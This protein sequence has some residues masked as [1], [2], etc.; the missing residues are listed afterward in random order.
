MAGQTFTTFINAKRTGSVDAEFAQLEQRAAR[1]LSGIQAKAEA[2]TKALGGLTG[3]RGGGGVNRSPIGQAY[4]NG[5]DQAKIRADKLREAQERLARENSSL[6]RGLRTTGQTLQIVQGPLGPIAGRVNAAADALARLTGVTLGLAGA[7]AALFAYTQAA[8][9]FVEIRSKLMPLFEAQ[10]DVNQALSD[11][12]GIAQR[13]RAGLEPVIDLYAKMKVGADQLGMSQQRV[14]RI[15][16][17]ASKAATLSGG[18]AQS[19]EAGLYQFSQGFGSGTLAGEE[20][21]SVKENT[22]ALARAISEGL[23]KLPEFKGIDTSIGKLKE[24]GEQG[25]LTAEVIARALEASAGSIEQR[26]SRLPP[27]LGA[28]MTALSNS[29]T[30][31]VGRFEEA[32]GIVGTL[33]SGVLLLGNNLNV[34][35]GVLGGVAAAWA[36]VAIQARAAQAF[37]SAR[38]FIANAQATRQSLLQA[39]EAAVNMRTAIVQRTVALE[40]E[41]RQI[42]QN[43]VALE[44]ELQVQREIARQGA[45]SAKAGL[46]GGAQQA[47]LGQAGAA[48]VTKELADEVEHLSLVQ[49]QAATTGRQLADANKKVDAAARGA[50]K[51]KSLLRMGLSNVLAMMN[52]LG[53]AV[54]LATTAFLNWALAESEAEKNARKVED[55]QRKLATVIDFTTGK[56]I[57]QNEAL[58]AGARL[59]AAGGAQ[60]AF[61]NYS[62]KKGE[63]LALGNQFKPQIRTGRQGMEVA[64]QVQTTAAQRAFLAALD[65][66]RAGNIDS[67]G[68]TKFTEALA[69]QDPAMRA[70]ADRVASLGGE[71]VEAAKEVES[72]KSSLRILQGTATDEDRR[73]A[74]KDFSG[75]RA[76]G[77]TAS[78][79]LIAEAEALR[80]RLRDQRFAAETQM[81][82]SLARLE[83]RRS[84]MT[85]DDYVRERAQILATYDTALQSI[86]KQDQ[87]A[88]RRAEREEERR[89]KAHE[90]ELARIEKENEARDRRTERRQDILGRWS[91]EPRAVERAKIDI[92]ELNDLVGK[93][94]NGLQAITQDN[95]LGQG[96]YTQEM[97]D[98]DA[99]RIREGL[100]RPYTEFMQQRQRDMNISQLILEGHEQEAEALRQT[101]DLYD[102]IGEVTMDQYQS[103]L[104]SLRAEE[105][106]NDALAQRERLMAPLRES[107][108]ALRSE[109]TGAIEDF[110]GGGN[111]LK[112]FKNV[113]TG[114][115]KSFNHQTAVQWAEKVTG[116][117]DQRVRDLIRGSVQVDTKI[118]DYLSALNASGDGATNLSGALNNAA[119]AAN[120][121]A[122]ALNGVGGAVDPLAPLPVGGA[123]GMG[124]SSIIGAASAALYGMMGANI[125]GS[126]YKSGVSLGGG[127]GDDVLWK[128]L[129]GLGGV[130]TENM[131]SQSTQDRYYAAGLTP[132]R[133]SDHTTTN[134]AYDVRPPAGMS[135]Q[136]A[137]N[138]VRKTA[139]EMGYQ[140]VKAIDETQSGGTGRHA[141]YVFGRGPATA[142]P[143]GGVLNT[144][145]EVAGSFIG[146]MPG[147]VAVQAIK[148]VAEIAQQINP[149]TAGRSA[150][151]SASVGPNGEIIITGTRQAS[152]PQPQGGVLSQ[153][154]Q[155]N[156]LGQQ[157]GQ[158]LDKI[159]G[160]KFLGKVGS[161]LG[162]TLQGIQYGQ[163]AS[164]VGSMLGI[165]QSNTGAMI[166]GAIG[167]LGY[168]IP[169]VG[170]IAGPILS[171]V[172]GFLGGT[173]GGMFKKTKKASVTVSG[174]EGAI[175]IG[176]AKGNSGKREEAA[177]Q[178]GSSLGDALQ[179]IVDQLDA[180]IGSFAVSI[181]MRK[182]KYVVDPSG[183]GQTKGSGVL[184]FD[185]A[186]EAIQAALMDAIRDGAIAGISAA[187]QTILKKAK[188][189]TTALNKVMVIE[190]IPKRLMQLK[191]PV[192]Y[193]IMELNDEFAKMI[194]YLKEGGATAQQFAE[195]QELYDLERQRIL[196]QTVN[197]SITAIQDYIDEMLGGSSSP[198]NR[199]TVYENAKSALNP[200]AADIK[201]GKSVDTTQFLQAV[202]NFQD[203]SRG[204]YG[205]SQSFFSDFNYL[206]GL[207]NQA[208]SNAQGSITGPGS[209]PASPFDDPTIQALINGTNGTTAAINYQTQV[210]GGYLAALL[211]GGTYR[212]PATSGS[213]APAT[214]ISQLPGS[215]GLRSP[216]GT[217]QLV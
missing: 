212:P 105:Q 138:L 190:S 101:Y 51:A 125:P 38:N 135:F 50:A 6:V 54:G 21:K 18:T 174:A 23:G 4:L 199:R 162:N 82:E 126:F 95:P 79:N 93:T 41:E 90:R 131:R 122:A 195:A 92:R 74:N 116:G 3:G 146:G 7:G 104:N 1:S 10:T 172:G 188:D 56:I 26:F 81:T 137:T 35:A 205:S 40:A 180:T 155:Y 34:V 201:A 152:T 163:M 89:K 115:F 59:Q 179:Q 215:S 120:N 108:G 149:P 157:L 143:S 141:H 77:E 99:E 20:L 110:L 100:Q 133:V 176:N 173:I 198:L 185:T 29:A 16:E 189:L 32:T 102:S 28:S 80:K 44:T 206:L 186:E 192:K 69:K 33:A 14:L 2:A 96:I 164:G 114:L 124:G 47:A 8:N 216:G 85:A 129:G 71:A 73:R 45:I 17:L 61:A 12:Y 213:G 53:I 43:I 214:A 170:A 202:Q 64:T 171:A 128:A 203:A 183:R 159:L 175:D 84:K 97:S 168:L 196:E 57:E 98:A 72:L 27:T 31:F 134:E 30:M 130:I 67:A 11:V 191:D 208:K 109:I 209:L 200:F 161:V 147:Q 58:L 91:D 49:T 160:T 132:A 121:A 211:N 55:A 87:A 68:L 207:L 24:L 154:E 187:S 117:L 112:G 193:A 119:T 151:G 39:Q 210:L 217:M 194:A 86:D 65:R 184:K 167:S 139:Q 166:G 144:A 94:M 36:A 153:R 118:A 123:L 52:P 15:T 70:L 19:R 197:N 25:K 63:I 76:Q 9:R 182:D 142:T 5:F 88:A 177:T 158:N 83:A 113:I 165:K 48:R 136:N 107:V 181:G 111:P 13:A 145:A 66:Y 148:S 22:L 140:L 178:M 37:D 46:P 127:I 62:A 106:I 150:T 75:G 169:G 156:M 103:I 42:R 78:R 60:A 204:L